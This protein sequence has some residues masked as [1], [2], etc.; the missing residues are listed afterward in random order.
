MFDFAQA[1]NG[2]LEF[3]N[4][5]KSCAGMS[6]VWAEAKKSDFGLA[7]FNENSYCW[8]YM[9][10]RYI[11]ASQRLRSIWTSLGSKADKPNPWPRAKLQTQELTN[12]CKLVLP[13]ALQRKYWDKKDIGEEE[14]EDQERLK[15]KI[16]PFVSKY[17]GCTT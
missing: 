7:Y 4:I 15:G 1:F 12:K 17:A 11:M 5:S 3:W 9:F 6:T 8:R 13:Y 16:E 2:N 10:G 14:E